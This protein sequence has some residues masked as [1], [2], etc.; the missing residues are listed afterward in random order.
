[1]YTSRRI[2][3][4][5]ISLRKM[6]E[7]FF[8]I[9]GAGHE[10]INVAAGMLLKPAFDW[11]Y[12]YYRDRTICLA[13]GMTE[14][15]ML[16]Q[17]TGAA[18][19]P[20][21]AGRQMPAHW[22]HRALNIVSSSSPTGTQFLQ[23]V[24]CAEAGGYMR[25][26]G[27]KGGWREEEVT[28]VTSGDGTTSQGEFWE[29]LSTACV[30]KLPML[31]LVEDNGYAISVPTS[32][33]TP[34]ANIAKA[35][36]GLE[37]LKV[38][39]GVD[40]SDPVASYGAMQEAVTHIRAGQG[41]VLM[42]ANVTRPYSHSLSDDHTMY[43]TKKELAIEKAR[44]CL[45]TFPAFLIENEIATEGELDALRD[46]VNQIVD[47]AGEQA[48]SA[49]KP[50]PSTVLDYLYSPSVDLCAPEL[51]TTPVASDTKALPMGGLINR[52]LMD[53]MARDPRIL[54]FG[55]DV[56]DA[57][58]DEVLEQCKG[59]G[60]VFK[61]TYGLQ[62]KFGNDRVFNSPL[63]EANIIGRAIGMATRGLK[64]VAEIQFFDY[65]WTAM[66]Q[67]RNELSMMRYRSANAFSCP[68][69]VRVTIGGYL[70][71]GAVYHSQCGESI[72]AHCPGLRVAF[73]SN[74]ADAHGLLRTALRGDD[75]VLFLEHKHLYFQGYNRAPYPGPDYTIP[76]GK[77]RIVREGTD[78]TV[79]S[80]GATVQRALNAALELEKEGVAVELIDLRTVSP[81]DWDAIASSVKKTSRV[82]VVHEDTLTGGFGGEIAAWISEHCFEWLDAPVRRIGAL[83]CPV[84][85]APVL[86]EVILPQTS[87]LA[88][89][90]RALAQY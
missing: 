90:M 32:V 4:K 77:A 2:D 13:L 73:P 40:G 3:D 37:G 71:G 38:M 15:E 67:L 14:L 80:W 89:G 69:V 74:A 58:N 48:V 84:A 56:A 86:E 60:G 31:F 22:G 68:V 55:E 6:N 75:P 21:S 8:Q 9:I 59:K 51:S 36:S 49:A 24:G 16:L 28:L 25:R 63:A 52:A 12:L 76:F 65:I 20:S 5:E 10:A 26:Q 62:R 57:T 45:T 33:Q 72:F 1:M 47:E 83:D 79:I 70:R 42:R 82:L 35:M 87:R 61:V 23:A 19:D 27:I 39:D 29:A 18:D 44:D 30:R 46:D 88:E 50:D 34:G 43:R 7:A 41:P 11:F 54:L 64:P 66:M 85:Y 53:E 78:V 17:A 81:V